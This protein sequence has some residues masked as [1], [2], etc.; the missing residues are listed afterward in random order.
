MPPV[1]TPDKKQTKT[2]AF[3]RWFGKSKVV[4]PDRKPLVVY[5]GTRYVGS[6]CFTV[7][8]PSRSKNRNGFFFTDDFAV[9]RTY[10]GA[11]LYP[12]RGKYDCG[13]YPVYLRMLNPLVVDAEGAY[14]FRLPFVLW[15]PEGELTSI[16]ADDLARR[17]KEK[18]HYDGIIIKNVRDSSDYCRVATSTVYIVFDPHNIKSALANAGTFDITDPDIRHNPASKSGVRFVRT[19]RLRRNPRLADPYEAVEAFMADC[20][21]GCS[22]A[23]EEVMLPVRPR[24]R[25]NNAAA[26]SQTDTAA[27]KKWFGKSKAA[28]A[29]GKPL[30]LYHGTN[31]GG[32]VEFDLGKIDKHH[33]GFFFTNSK[34][35]AESYGM[36]SPLPSRTNLVPDIRTVADIRRFVKSPEN[37]FADGWRIVLHE[38]RQITEPEVED[39]GLSYTGMGAQV[40]TTFLPYWERNGKT[41]DI[42]ESYYYPPYTNLV[43]DIREALRHGGP[44]MSGTY[45]VYARMLKPLVVDGKG[46]PWMH[47]PY[48]GGYYKTNQLSAIA[49]EK[50]HDGLILRNIYDSNIA[51][52]E[53]SDVYVVFDPHNIKSATANVGTFDRK[54]AD[55][56]MNPPR[57]RNGIDRAAT[58]TPL[59]P[60]VAAF[61]AE[62]NERDMDTVFADMGVRVDVLVSGGDEVELEL[63]ESRVHKQ[64]AGSRALRTLLDLVDKHHLGVTLNAMPFSSDARRPPSLDDLVRLYQRFGFRVEEEVDEDEDEEPESYA[65]YRS[66]R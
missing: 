40:T 46:A 55:I 4:G 66:R 35:V 52:D 47:I 50:G 18:G 22:Q 12:P 63:I 53:I 8:D 65:M 30:V 57:R 51:Q 59:T 17:T 44:P 48:K 41:E 39:Y 61:M 58:S 34:V 29:D 11:G 5:H 54:N 42:G 23:E 24:L 64:G 3:K 56:R 13:V 25:H 49:K 31:R 45:A 38:S 20:A 21:H 9:A 60:A 2:L 26:G 15:T 6:E 62:W 10:G 19:P 7:F 33:S 43:P 1:F 32:F 37:N 36:G 28:D 16:S 27:F 14:G